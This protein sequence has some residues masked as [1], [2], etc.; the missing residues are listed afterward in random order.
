EEKTQADRLSMSEGRTA[1]R[2]EVLVEGEIMDAA[3]REPLP[4]RIYIR[5]VDGAWHFPKATSTRGS[6]IRYERRNWINTNVVEMHTTLSAHPFRVELLPGRYTFTIERGEEFFPETGE[7]MVE[8]GLPKQ[9]FRLRRWVNMA[10]RGWYSG[11]TH[12]HREPSELSNVMLAE[13]VNVGLPMVDWTTAATVAPSASDRGFRGSFG[14][15]PVSIDA[16]HVW[17]TRNTE[18]EIFT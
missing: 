5:G 13:D 15:V 9:T 12:N 8:R 7:V 16:T 10:E 14:D 4:A 1:G 3:S 18:Y 11:D 6:A 17:Q 2:K